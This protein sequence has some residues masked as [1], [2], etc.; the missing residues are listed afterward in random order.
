MRPTNV[1]FRSCRPNMV[2][3][4]Q[5]LDSSVRRMRIS[6]AYVTTRD[7][8]QA[9]MQAGRHPNSSTHS[10]PT[11]NQAR[12]PATRVVGAVLTRNHILGP[13][14]GRNVS[15]AGAASNRRRRDAAF[16][17]LPPI[18]LTYLSGQALASRAQRGW[19]RSRR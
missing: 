7:D 1:K 10:T 17:L 6:F 9:G 12:P 11:K 4:R 15:A 3:C 8:K 2:N 14:Y 18:Q 13:I 16:I 5:C 19:F